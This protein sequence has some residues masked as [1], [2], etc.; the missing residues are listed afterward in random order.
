MNHFLFVAVPRGLRTCSVL[1]IW[2]RAVGLSI[3][4]PILCEL[5]SVCSA[6]HSTHM[7]RVSVWLNDVRDFFWRL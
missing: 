6:W 1:V 3:S 5:R 7:V 4:M 2:H